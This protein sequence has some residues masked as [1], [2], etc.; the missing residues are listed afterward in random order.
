MENHKMWHILKNGRLKSETG[1][2]VGPTILGTR[3][4]GYFSIQVIC[5]Q[6]VVIRFI[7]QKFLC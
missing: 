6:F 1:K 7:L 5:V 4:V 3:Y 2:N